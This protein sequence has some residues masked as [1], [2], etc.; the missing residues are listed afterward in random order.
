M[1]PQVSVITPTKNRFSLLCE[2]MDSVQAQ[3]FQDWEHLII[4]DGSDDGTAEEVARR[5]AAD[6]RIR[7]IKRRGENA[8]A[9]ICRNIGIR[10]AQ[11]DLIVFLDSDDLLA[12][13]CLDQR[14]AKMKRNRD[15]DFAV[16]PGW[17]FSTT[18]EEQKPWFI[19][20][21]LKSDLDLVLYLEHPW[22]TTGPIWR[23]AALEKIGFLSERL[24]S[25][26]DVDL[27]VRAL[28]GRL[29][30]LKFD[31]PDHHIRW[32]SDPTKTSVR[33]FTSP[34]HLEGGID[35]VDN[36]QARLLQTG[37]MTWARRRALGGLLFLLAER[38]IHIGR[39][40]QGLQVWGSAY[41]KGFVPLFVYGV[42]FLV[43]MIFRLKLL[44][45]TYSERLLE[46][47]KVATRLR[48]QPP[49]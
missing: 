11:A 48:S 45:P 15:L 4:D 13:N 46:R 30:Y 43:L 29:K 14:V 47:F 8:G 6:L 39:L 5:A 9:N 12:P 20:P 16:F 18:V 44:G 7:Y 17:S 28:T 23:R 36:F 41:R 1:P 42:G 35:I 38:W 21:E 19:P 33:Q 2:T 25:W 32:N 27:N 26:Q 37:L 31:N 49:L 40:S 24:L 3:S 34:N 22:Q 10:E